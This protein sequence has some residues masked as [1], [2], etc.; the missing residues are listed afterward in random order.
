MNKKE[1]R[2]DI[3]AKRNRLEAILNDKD[4][5]EE[6]DSLAAA[7]DKMV[8]QLAAMNKA[9]EELRAAKEAEARVPAPPAEETRTKGAWG[10]IRSALLEQRAVTAN[11]AGTVGVVS[12]LFK[13]FVEKNKVGPRI[14]KFYGANAS[15]VIPVFSPNIA[16]PAKQTEGGTSIAADSTG[17]LGPKTL[18]PYPYYSI[19]QVS[20]MALMSTPIEQALPEIFADAFAGAIDNAALVGTAVADGGL[21]VFVASASGVPT[22]SDVDC[23]ASGS[24]K[25]VDIVGLV[26]KAQ[27]VT[28]N[29]DNVAVYMHPTTFNS[30]LADTTAEWLVAKQQLF[31]K[32]MMG[33]PIIV[34]NRVP[35][36]TTAGTYLAVA[37]DF[38]Q[39]A[40]AIAAE[41]SIDQIKVVGSDNIT[42]QA[43]MYMNFSPIQGAF[44]RRLKTISG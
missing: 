23:A 12:E 34:T 13:A 41:L 27:A 11:G 33:S 15:T 2:E 24:P 28:D 30:L 39:Y 18:T 43:W 38:S 40:A 26:V 44:F 42:F 14:R 9:D 4:K 19:L 36:A 21:G 1:L 16:L 25:I 17:V 7:L 32:Q 8:P 20:R 10:E 31:A 6:R 22:S 5:A 35:Y 29:P 37:G 3:E